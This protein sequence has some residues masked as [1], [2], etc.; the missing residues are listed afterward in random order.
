DK[1][2]SLH[3]RQAA[4]L[5]QQR[6]MKCQDLFRR[7][8][9]LD[10]QSRLERKRGVSHAAKIGCS[11]MNKASEKQSRRD[12]QDHG[13]RDLSREQ[14][15]SQRCPGDA[16]TNGARRVL[17]SSEQSLTCRGN[18]R[19]QPGKQSSEKH[20][21]NSEGGNRPINLDSICTRQVA[22]VSGKP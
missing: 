9:F 19:C 14:Y 7:F 16:A 3:D 21:S 8:V 2:G 5:R 20:N 15:L 13:Q 6:F 11:E 17:Q 1:P 18:C 4:H 22:P 12:K 10:W